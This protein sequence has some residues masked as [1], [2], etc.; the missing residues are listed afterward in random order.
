MVNGNGQGIT[1]YNA[2]GNYVI[3]KALP[4]MDA[5]QI[6]AMFDTSWSGGNIA[7]GAGGSFGYSRCIVDL[8]PTLDD[9]KNLQDGTFPMKFTGGSTPN[10]DEHKTAKLVLMKVDAISGA[11]YD[12]FNMGSRATDYE[13]VTDPLKR[14]YRDVDAIVDGAV[15]DKAVVTLGNG[16]SY[17]KRKVHVEKNTDVEEDLFAVPMSTNWDAGTTYKKGDCVRI[18]DD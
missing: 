10:D 16:G 4:I 6:N 2:D 18:Y 17:Q 8:N 14:K 12:T 7:G 5:S 13:L 15:D 3:A 11:K 1:D 9:Y